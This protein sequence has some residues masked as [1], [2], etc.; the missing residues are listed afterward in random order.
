MV[1]AGHPHQPHLDVRRRSGAGRRPTSSTCPCAARRRCCSA[2]GTRSTWPCRCRWARRRRG[3]RTRSS[4]SRSSGPPPGAEVFEALTPV[5]VDSVIALDFAATVTDGLGTGETTPFAASRQEN[6]ELYADYEV[7]EVGV[8]RRARLR[9][10]RRR[11]GRRCSRPRT[12]RPRTSIRSTTPSLSSSPKFTSEL[13]FQWERDLVRAGKLDAR[14]L[15][16]ELR[17]PVHA[18]HGEPDRRR[19]A[20]CATRTRRAAASA[21]RCR[22]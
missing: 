18:H 7:V 2:N 9:A 5:P 8:R 16:L 4:S 11:A 21:G 3:G 12:P 1:A 6:G 22:G 19:R 14:R 20:G 17:D 13:S 15:L 10:G